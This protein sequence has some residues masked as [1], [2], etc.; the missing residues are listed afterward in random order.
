MFAAIATRLVARPA[1]VPLDELFAVPARR[2]SSAAA[3]TVRT[4]AARVDAGRGA[5]ASRRCAWATTV[6]A[7]ARASSAP[8]RGTRCRTCFVDPPAASRAVARRRATTPASPIVTVNLWFDRPVHRR[9]RSSACRDGRCSGCSTSGALFGEAA[10]HLSLVSSGA[11]AIVGRSND[12]L[13]ALALERAAR[14]A[15]GRRAAAACAAPSWSARSGR[16]S[17]W[18][19]AARRV[20]VRDRRAGPV[21]RRRL[22]RHRPP[23]Y[24]RERG[25]QRPRG[26][27][28][29]RL[30]T[31]G[32]PSIDR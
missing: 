17:R 31:C 8:C 30:V 26:R 5:G 15:A 13:I 16:R 22:D 18:R 24:D 1:A 27:A 23:R 29:A 21:P 12:E 20:R 6:I 32:M 19:Q 10:S 2:S 11:D 9:R 7:A 3:A 4:S 28:C 25:C 14:G